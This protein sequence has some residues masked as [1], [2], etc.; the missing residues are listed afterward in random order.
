MDLQNTT[1]VSTSLGGHLLQNILD[2]LPA[3]EPSTNHGEKYLDIFNV[4][5]SGIEDFGERL[6]DYTDTWTE[7]EP[8]TRGRSLLLPLPDL[9]TSSILS[10]MSVY[11]SD[12]PTSLAVGTVSSLMLLGFLYIMGIQP[13]HEDGRFLPIYVPDH[14]TERTSRHLFDPYSWTHV[15]HGILGHMALMGASYLVGE[16]DTKTETFWEQGGGLGITI[17]GGMAWEIIENTEYIINKFRENSGTSADY[18]GDSYINVVGDMISVGVG[19]MVSEWGARH[20]GLWFSPVLFFGMEIF[21]AWLIRDN[22]FLINQQLFFPS[23]TI[24][25]WQQEII[26]E[27]QRESSTGLVKLE[28]GRAG[29]K[30]LSA[31]VERKSE[32]FKKYVHSQ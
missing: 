16:P 28:K 19:Y 17:L 13:G 10:R 21:L 15:N 30:E 24:L 20:I 23:Q 26:P 14:Y 4:I 11:S 9:E 18:K 5:V 22:Y 29:G 1:I 7:P 31:L 3:S 27:D 2:N 8:P 12:L 25:K 6:D 32:A